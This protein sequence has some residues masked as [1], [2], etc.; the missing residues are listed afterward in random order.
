MRGLPFINT[1]TSPGPRDMYKVAP[2]TIVIV[3]WLKQDHIKALLSGG[4]RQAFGGKT[5]GGVV[6]S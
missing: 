6:L 3:I 2:E 1:M 4:L 5:K